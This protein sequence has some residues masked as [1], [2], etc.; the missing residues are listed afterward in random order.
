MVTGR[1]IIKSGGRGGGVTAKTALG[2][3]DK[4][5]WLPPY[6]ETIV[7]FFLSILPSDF[8]SLTFVACVTS[9]FSILFSPK[10]LKSTL[11][12]YNFYFTFFKFLK[13]S[14]F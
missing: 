14:K 4:V 3:Q 13:N 11:V 10:N 12:F 8:S 9:N 5:L 2:V 1:Q 7:F 6:K